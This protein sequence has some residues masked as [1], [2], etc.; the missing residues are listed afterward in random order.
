MTV[1]PCGKEDGQNDEEDMPYEIKIRKK[2]R[3]RQC[4]PFYREREQPQRY[5]PAQATAVG[6]DIQVPHG[7]GLRAQLQRLPQT[8]RIRSRLKQI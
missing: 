8:I 6:E 1:I 3:F 5:L 7:S 4:L 2:R